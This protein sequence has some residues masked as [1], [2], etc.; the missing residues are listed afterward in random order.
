MQVISERE[1]PPFHVIIKSKLKEINRSKRAYLFVAPAFLLICAIIFYP[2]ANTF[3]ISLNKVN[4]IGNPSG[5]NNFQNYTHLF[6]SKEF[7]SVLLQTLNWTLLVVGITTLISIPTALALNFQFPGRKLARGILI[8]PW[9]TSLMIN[10]I[11]W[12]WIFDGQYSTITYTLLKFGIIKNPIVWLGDPKFS[13]AIIVFVGILV[14]IPSTTLSILAGL[15]SIPDDIYEAVSL[16]GAGFLVSFWHLTLPQL[17]HTLTV[18][19]ILNVIYV[20]NSFPIIW[21][22]TQGG[23]S[24]KTDIL[25]TY[26][27]KQAFQYNN[28]GGASAMAII[29]FVILVIFAN[30]FQRITLK[31]D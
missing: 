31:E 22:L 4:V 29:T 23:P 26:L 9:A 11:T 24:F 18:T 27:Y 8:V 16:E 6:V 10:A 12:K 17:R 13:F 21:I 19:T 2:I 30:L 3:Y 20:F 7:L 28:F 15:Q 14:S 1:K 25:V 5:F